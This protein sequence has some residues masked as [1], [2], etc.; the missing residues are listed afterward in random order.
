MYVKQFFQL[1]NE[2]GYYKV[3]N[4]E[5]KEK[6]DIKVNIFLNHLNAMVLSIIFS[7]NILLIDLTGAS[8]SLTI[9]F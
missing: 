1:K 8:Q 9:V 6:Q 2:V 3:F 5:I 7:F 4:L